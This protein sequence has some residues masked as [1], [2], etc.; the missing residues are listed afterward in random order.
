MSL[1][2]SLLYQNSNKRKF[3]KKYNCTYKNLL[4]NTILEGGTQK[5]STKPHI[6]H[7]DQPIFTTVSGRPSQSIF[8]YKSWKA[9]AKTVC[10]GAFTR[11]ILCNPV[12]VHWNSLLQRIHLTLFI[13]DFI[14]PLPHG[15]CIF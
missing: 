15:F 2:S 5:D 8:Q 13:L 9:M 1:M 14:L 7:H 12:C 4:V 6:H 11:C 3:I 10:E